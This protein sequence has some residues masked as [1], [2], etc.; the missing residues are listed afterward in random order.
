MATQTRC[1]APL[2]PPAFGVCIVTPQDFCPFSVPTPQLQF[3][4]K[5]LFAEGESRTWDLAKLKKR[6]L[7]IATWYIE[8]NYG[9]QSGP[10]YERRQAFGAREANL[11]DFI[12]TFQAVDDSDRFR[13]AMLTRYGS[14]LSFNLLQRMTVDLV[15]ESNDTLTIASAEKLTLGEA[16]ERLE[17]AAANTKG[18]AAVR[19]DS[20]PR[21]RLPTSEILD[22][23]YWAI[24]DILDG[25]DNEQGEEVRERTERVVKASDLVKQLEQAGH[26]K[27]AAHWAIHRRIV[28]GQ[29]TVLGILMGGIG[30]WGGPGESWEVPLG[31]AV[32]SG[33]DYAMFI[34]RSTPTLWECHRPNAIDQTLNEQDTSVRVAIR[35]I[36]NPAPINPCVSLS[37][38]FEPIRNWLV[39][40][41][42]HDPDA[43]TYDGLGEDPIVF[44]RFTEL[45][46]YL[47]SLGADVL[48]SLEACRAAGWIVDLKVELFSGGE[49]SEPA[50]PYL[51][52]IIRLNLPQGSHRLVGI[53]KGVLTAKPVAGD[54]PPPAT[55]ET[56]GDYGSNLTNAESNALKAEALAKRLS[57]EEGNPLGNATDKQVFDWLNDHHADERVKPF[58]PESLTAFKAA[59]G[60]ARGKMRKRKKR[61]AAATGKSVVRQADI[62][63]KS[64]HS[65]K[66]T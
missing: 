42:L 56:K 17:K 3:V 8:C 13:T 40:H 66:S 31:R 61:P 45:A 65:D 46:N 5:P 59:L 50:L 7:D 12:Q 33:R 14:D 2:G 47:V 11:S 18:K 15:R 29:L 63:P 21:F 10:S 38:A 24:P 16:V 34:V 64:R 19:F 36:G 44:E 49:P 37:P 30:A 4:G 25:M 6:L 60:R 22:A 26:T 39:A 28:D 9:M 53:R 20:T 27:S 54:A 32:P 51:E 52:S 62:E 58:L 23:A 55:Q 48:P 1:D 43:K 41:F 57:E 35:D